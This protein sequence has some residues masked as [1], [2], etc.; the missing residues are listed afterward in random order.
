LFPLLPGIVGGRE[1][2]SALYVHMFTTAL[3]MIIA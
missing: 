1:F 3:A 2:V